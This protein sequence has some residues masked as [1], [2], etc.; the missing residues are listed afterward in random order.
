[1][2]LPPRIKRESDR[3]NA[4]RRSPASFSPNPFV[5][6][7]ADPDTLIEFR[8]WIGTWGE[9]WLWDGRLNERGYGSFRLH[10]QH[11]SAH[12]AAYL[13]FKGP[14]CGGLHVLHSCDVRHCVNPDHLRLGTHLE[15][16]REM[17]AKGRHVAPR[18]ERARSAKLNEDE[19]RAIRLE[20]GP[21]WKVGSRYGV[22][23]S[24]I[25]AIRNNKI[26]RHVA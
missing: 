20:D 22:S 2:F 18:G 11:I 1:M 9:C 12:R 16:M 24:L 17:V 23:A 3:K 8:A 14:I 25:Q 10:N 4:G 15:N 19:V 7:H 13:L 21:A 6:L 5:R 26:W